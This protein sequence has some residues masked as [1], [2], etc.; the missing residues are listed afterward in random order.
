M[1]LTYGAQTWTAT[2]TLKNK[3]QTTQRAM[4]R[5][6]IGVKRKDRIIRNVD[7]RKITGCRDVIE[8]IQKQK[9]K[10]AGHVARKMKAM[11]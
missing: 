4:E 2:K 1:K 11:R 7:I 5:S 3:L 10:F 9:I 6:I 8:L